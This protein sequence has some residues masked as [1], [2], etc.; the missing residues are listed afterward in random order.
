MDDG[1]RRSVTRLMAGLGAA[2][3]A[4]LLARPERVVDALAP[5]FPRERL[6]VARLLGARLVAQHG[7]L[8]VAPHPRLLRQSSAVDVLHA[9]SMVPVLLLPRYRR[10]ALISG[11]VAVGHALAERALAGFQRR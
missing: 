4:V 10:A 11:G 5:A 2:S 3:G 1:R 6:W 7:T 8:L 9:A